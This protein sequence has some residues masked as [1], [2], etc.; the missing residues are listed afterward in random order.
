MLLASNIFLILKNIQLTKKVE[1]SKLFVTE[2]GY[3]F[4]RL[5]FNRLDGHEETVNFSGEG[6][7]TLLFVFSPSCNYCVQQYASWKE[8]AGNLDY[9]RW[10]VLAV[11]SEDSYDKIRAHIEEHGLSD[12]KVGSMSK[13]DMRRSRML[14]TP[15]TLIIDANGEVKRVWPGLWKKG[16]DMSGS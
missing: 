4:S 6:L 16:F 14:F 15:M 7:K 13:E 3:K 5:K 1:E 9:T 10:R 12:I 8:L 2:E 11:T